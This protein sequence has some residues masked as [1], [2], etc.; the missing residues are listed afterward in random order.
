VCPADCIVQHPAFVESPD[1][2]MAKYD[3]LHG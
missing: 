2:L 1:A 3:T